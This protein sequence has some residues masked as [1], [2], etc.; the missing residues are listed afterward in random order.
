MA[1]VVGSFGRVSQA[2]CVAGGNRQRGSTLDGGDPVDLP[3]TQQPVDRRRRIGAEMASAAEGELVNIA[4]YKTVRDVVAG[5]C[6]V[7]QDVVAVLMIRA[8]VQY[9]RPHVG[10]L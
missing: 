10:A 1:V 2:G 4:R 6:A 9:L 5:D 7:G 8:I 3:A